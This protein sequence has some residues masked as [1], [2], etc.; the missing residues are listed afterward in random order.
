[1]KHLFTLLAGAITTFAVHSQSHVALKFAFMNNEQPFAL[2]ETIEALNGVD[3]SVQDVAFYVSRIKIVHDGGQILEL[4]T[5][6][7]LYISHPNNSVELGELDV[8]NI[9]GIHFMV[10]VPEYLNHL[11]IS[12]YPENHPL[13]YQTPTMH[14]GWTAG[15]MHFIINALGD[16]NNDGTPTEAYQ[17]HCLGDH[18]TPDVSVTTVA[19]VYQNGSQ[20]IILNVNLDQ[21]LE[22]TDPATT[23]M[24][25]GSN[26][27]N[28]AV[29]DNVTQHPVFT[30]PVNASVIETELIDVQ[31]A[32]LTTA[33]IISWDE[34]VAAAN[35][36]LTNA[37]GRV[38]ASGNCNGAELRFENLTPGLHFV[39]LYSGKQDLLGT[40]KWIVP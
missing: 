7:V 32:Q 17:L 40:A 2:N 23:G 6:K 30:S 11:D 38:I 35:Y 29:M 33:T 25:H 24:V 22:G 34:Q 18:N 9:E 37:E 36:R 28:A 1:M 4:D 12:Q 10:G 21:W 13:S 16:N 19:T 20:E 15:Y 31:V 14:W 5:N 27:V 39:Q 3:Y 26:G 8:T